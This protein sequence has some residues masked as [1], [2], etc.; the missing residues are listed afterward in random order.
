MFSL[1]DSILL[2]KYKKL[3]LIP[4]LLIQGGFNSFDFLFVLFISYQSKIR[5]IISTKLNFHLKEQLYIGY[6]LFLE[7]ALT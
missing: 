3:G 7:P 1:D 5:R 2:F 6:N 4:E